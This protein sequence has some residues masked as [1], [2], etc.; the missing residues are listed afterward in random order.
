M[1][2]RISSLLTSVVPFLMLL[3]SSMGCDRCN[4]PSE[5]LLKLAVPSK[6]CQDLALYFYLRR[7]LVTKFTASWSFR[8]LA[9]RCSVQLFLYDFW[10]LLQRSVS[11]AVELEHHWKKYCSVSLFSPSVPQTTKHSSCFLKD[12]LPVLKEGF[13]W[14]GHAFSKVSHEP[15]LNSFTWISLLMCLLPMKWYQILLLRC[16]CRAL[17]S[18]F[19]PSCFYP[20]SSLKIK[21]VQHTTVIK[22][23]CKKRKKTWC[24]LSRVHLFWT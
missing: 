17:P 23:Y 2:K 12:F 18:L 16:V 22:I 15:F 1:I 10:S 8:N 11:V 7:S 20:H 13:L 6:I 9:G 14:I 19:I 4:C 21:Q 24:W 5:S 3:T